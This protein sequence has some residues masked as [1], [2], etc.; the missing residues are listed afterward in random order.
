MT[1]EVAAR[2]ED[3]ECQWWCGLTDAV[4]ENI[5]R[6]VND[7]SVAKLTYAPWGPNEPNGRDYE[8]CIEARFKVSPNGTEKYMRWNDASCE[9][10][11]RKFFCN[12]AET[13]VF[14]LRGLSECQVSTL[15]MF[16]ATLFI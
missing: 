4:E 2:C 7:Q 3:T 5:W 16:L 14:Y 8:N 15:F 10:C 11:N 13:P 9:K 1:F 6:N 12:F